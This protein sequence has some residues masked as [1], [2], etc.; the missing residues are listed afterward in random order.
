MPIVLPY[1]FEEQSYPGVMTPVIRE[2]SC[3]WVPD[4]GAGW[5]VDYDPQ[6]L[7]SMT[8]QWL[9]PR[10][11]DLPLAIRQLLSWN[12]DKFRADALFKD[13]L[14][15]DNKYYRHGLVVTGASLKPELTSA[16]PAI[17]MGHM[18]SPGF[19]DAMPVIC[20]KVCPAGR[21]PAVF[22]DKYRLTLQW[23]RDEFVNR[24]GIKY[25]KVEIAPSIR[26]ESIHGSSMGV[27]PMDVD[28]GPKTD[29]AADIRKLTIGFPQREPQILIR[30]TYPWV[31]MGVQGS[32]A[33]GD[34]TFAGPLGQLT[35]NELAPGK[36]PIGQ[37]LG[38]VNQFNFLGF[39]RG[40]VLY[41]TATLEQRI[42]PV[43][44]KLGFQVTHEFLALSNSSWNMTRIES[45]PT[46]ALDK[47]S[48]AQEPQWPYG[49][50]VAIKRDNTV[51]LINDQPVFPYVHK[52]FANLLYYGWGDGPN[53]N[54]PD[55]EG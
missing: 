45:E 19:A 21:F 34:I 25:A 30:V 14:A 35:D 26:L 8:Q 20:G 27:A 4:Y 24:F 3:G 46:S 31:Q 9:V 5:S 23:S 18:Q 51:L 6:G 7:S 1:Q 54:I 39:R 42:S 37:Y 40:S 33:L 47:E 50:V 2:T 16:D 49:H 52:D 43:T 22:T 53:L 48:D 13:A 29:V 32:A 55:D 11:G 36:V 10:S 12:R 41:Q 15:Y 38:T 28:G 17:L 44:G